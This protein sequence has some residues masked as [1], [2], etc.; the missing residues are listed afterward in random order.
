M[1]Y[2]SY[3]ISDL[4]LHVTV[5]CISTIDTLILNLASDCTVDIYGFQYGA[6]A[7]IVRQPETAHR[8]QP[9]LTCQRHVSRR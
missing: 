4:I 2:L 9:R 7:V 6:F 3:L 1:R 5:Q 8:S